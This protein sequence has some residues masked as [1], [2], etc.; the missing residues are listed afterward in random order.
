MSLLELLVLLHVGSTAALL[1]LLG[2][3]IAVQRGLASLRA[4]RPAPAPARAS[5]QQAVM[6][7]DLRAADRRLS[8]EPGVA[9]AARR[10]S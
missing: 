5:E 6:G 8:H 3:V 7:L 1:L 2:G 10:S 4:H 9:V